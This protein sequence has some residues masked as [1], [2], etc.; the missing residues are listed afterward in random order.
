MM[1]V[2]KSHN[3][4]SLDI[5]TYATGVLLPIL[6]VPQAYSVLVDKS[7]EG[8]SLITWAFYLLSSTLFAI[9]GIVHKERLLMITYIPFVAVEAAIVVGILMN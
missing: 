2:V 5:L 1:K 3:H 9:F 7:T 4:K 8:V 6:T